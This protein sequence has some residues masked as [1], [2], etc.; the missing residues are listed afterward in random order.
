M[1]N[2]FIGKRADVYNKRGI[3]ALFSNQ[4]QLAQHW[5]NQAL[6]LSDKHFDSQCNYSMHRWNNGSTSDAQLLAE[7]E[8]FVF[9]VEGKGETMRA[10]LL[11]AMGWREE[12]ME[13]LSQFIAKNEASLKL[14]TRLQN[15]KKNKVLKQ[16][17]NV[18]DVIQNNRVLFTQNGSV[19]H[20]HDERITNLQFSDTGEFIISAS[21]DVSQ[22][23]RLV[24]NRLTKIIDIPGSTNNENREPNVSTLATLNSTCTVAAVYRGKLQFNL[25]EL[26]DLNSYQKKTTIDLVSLFNKSRVEGFKF[27]P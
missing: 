23:W 21:S 12:G 20:E 9:T 24:Q 22:V 26:I 6:E 17:Q 27:V 8:E 15:L 16:A 2:P 5:W 1:E 10:Y 18:F 19:K 4:E 25:Y 11:I 13:M 14:E 7:M 3:V